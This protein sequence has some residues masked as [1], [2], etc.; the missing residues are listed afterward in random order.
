M[1]VPSQ[2]VLIFLA[3]RQPVAVQ[4]RAGMQQQQQ[5]GAAVAVQG[6]EGGASGVL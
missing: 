1:K 4:R 6:G 3:N 5:Q 2:R